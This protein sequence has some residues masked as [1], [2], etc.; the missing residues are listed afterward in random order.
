V[1]TIKPLITF[2]TLF[3]QARSFRPFLVGILLGVALMLLTSS[4]PPVASQR[5]T[6]TIR[7]STTGLDDRDCGSPE[8]PCRSITYALTRAVSGDTILV[9]QGTYT[10][11]PNQAKCYEYGYTTAV[12]CIN[13][14][15]LTI[16]GGYSGDD[17]TTS[18]WERYPT[19]IDGGGVNRGILVKNSALRLEGFTLQNCLAAGVYYGSIVETSAYG[20]AIQSVYSALTLRNLIFRNN[21]AQGGAVD[22]TIGGRAVGA[23]LSM[24][25]YLSPPTFNVLENVRFE[26]NVAQGG[27][28]QNLGG[29]AVGG[30][31]HVYNVIVSAS[32]VTFTNNLAQ[33]GDTNGAGREWYDSLQYYLYADAQGGAAAFYNGSVVNFSHVTAIGNRALGGNAPNGDAGGAFGG[34]FYLEHGQA[35]YVDTVLRDNLAQGGDGLNPTPGAAIAEGGALQ[36][37]DANVA[38]DRALVV[39][40]VA[41]GGNGGYYRGPVGGGGL[42]FTHFDPVFGNVI[43]KNSIIGSNQ[44]LLAI[45]GTIYG[46]GGGGLWLQGMAGVISHT[47]IAGNTVSD[48]LFAPGA[49]VIGPVKP[50]M[51]E[52]QVVFDYTL[53]ADHA[54]GIEHIGAG[55]ALHVQPGSVVTLTRGLWSNNQFPETNINVAY[56]GVITGLD[57]MITGTANF[58]SPGAPDFD[59]HIFGRSAARDAAVGSGL[60]IDIDG[61]SRTLLAPPDIGADE[62]L[63]MILAAAPVG[64]GRLYAS[65]LTEPHL[66]AQVDHY[67]VIVEPTVD[68]APPSEGTTI[69]VGSA[70]G[71]MLTGLTDGLPYTVTVQAMSAGPTVLETSNLVQAIPL[72]YALF[73]PTTRR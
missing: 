73:L 16:L 15:D 28:G 13:R 41:R 38:M 36:S 43:I 23:A 32:Y 71:L 53:F 50:T 49:I 11:P 27:R 7:V 60:T 26:D 14:K 62:Y 20:G 65:W 68:A 69:E 17:W 25:N 9:A 57:T 67:L 72:P 54:G 61:E 66:A 33:A 12:L 35:Q 29:V 44:A 42:A 45:T 22:M 47:T 58:A 2:L 21:R 52:S 55:H 6:G 8:M 63:P 31:L 59:Y 24:S 39:N 34:A 70:V 51:P 30:A 5:G 10:L 46:G 37:D 1:N 56:R 48:G 19:I 18:D 64:H 4:V 3:W 40:N